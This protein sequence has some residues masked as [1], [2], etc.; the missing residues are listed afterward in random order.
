MQC[1]RAQSIKIDQSVRQNFNLHTFRK[2]SLASRNARIIALSVSH[3]L[4]DWK[5][6]VRDFV[7][8]FKNFPCVTRASERTKQKQT[9]SCSFVDLRNECAATHFDVLSPSERRFR[10]SNRSHKITV[11]H[12]WLVKHCTLLNATRRHQNTISSWSNEK[13]CIF[14]NNVLLYQ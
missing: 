3:W 4:I 11:V 14:Y 2:W 12:H 5:Q 9:E 10:S 1:R 13:W 8:N 6:R 7:L